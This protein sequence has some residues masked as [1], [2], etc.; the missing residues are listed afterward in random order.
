MI[1]D[2]QRSQQSSS[3]SGLRSGA[4]AS[5]GRGQPPRTALHPGARPASAAYA[6][7]D[8]RRRC[9]RFARVV[10]AYER[11]VRKYPASGYADNALWQ[12]ANCRR[13][14][15]DRFGEDSDKRTGVRLLTQL[16]A[17]YPASSLISGVDAAARA[18]RDDQ[19]DGDHGQR[20]LRRRA[21]PQLVRRGPP[22]PRHE[23][24]R[25]K[26]SQIGVVTRARRSIAR[27][28]PT[29]SASPSRWT[30]K[31][32]SGRSDSTT[33]SGSSSICEAPICRPRCAT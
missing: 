16:Q 29:A 27:R 4:A 18:L 14:A 3:P 17:G 15:W 21:R 26:R 6:T 7:R 25:Q 10:A 23:L 12:A 22:R 24:R 30:A 1:Y 19:G 8:N 11:V 33:R 28:C 5:I 9:A 32:S 31:S 20:P 13:L 2:V